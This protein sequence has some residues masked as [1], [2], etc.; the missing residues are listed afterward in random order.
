MVALALL[1]FPATW[2]L[3]GWCQRWLPQE[4]LLHIL[5]L[6][7]GLLVPPG[8]GADMSW[9]PGAGAPWPVQAAPASPGAAGCG[10]PAAQSLTLGLID[11]V[12]SAVP[13]LAHQLAG[14]GGAGI[15]PRSQM[16]PKLADL[17]PSPHTISLQPAVAPHTFSSSGSHESSVRDRTLEQWTPKLLDGKEAGSQSG[18][19]TAP[20]P[21]RQRTHLWMPEH[22]MQSST[23]RLMLAQRGSG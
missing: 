1:R 8:P 2:G 19:A 7:P 20:H 21:A 3:P 9:P 15:S 4:L 5:V 23:P 18:S 14:E 16:P 6:D 22:S 13:K 12:H 11:L 17:T 10:L